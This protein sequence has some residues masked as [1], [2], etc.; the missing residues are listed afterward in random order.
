MR[1]RK[2]TKTL[3]RDKAHRK[4]LLRNLSEQL[5]LNESIKTTKAK[6]KELQKFIEP[7]IT[8]AS[9]GDENARRYLFSK[10]GDKTEAVDKLIE[11][12][13]PTFE[14]RPGGY[15]R[16]IKLPHRDHDAAERAL[17]EFVE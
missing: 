11:E 14:D 8:K 17:I 9:E 5:I 7:L 15:T 16:I 12:L 10:L 1:H 3:G 13:G 6:A 4:Q 2:K